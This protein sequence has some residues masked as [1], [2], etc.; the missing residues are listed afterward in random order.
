MTTAPT[1]TEREFTAQVI[2]LARLLGWRTAHFRPAWTGR[3]WRT[4]VQGDGAGFPD[5]VLV[6]GAPVIA[7]ELKAGKGKPS[8]EQLAWLRDLAA[9]GIITAVWR[10]E[11]FEEIAE[12][13]R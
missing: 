6:R 7:A 11:Q 8:D 12:V 4:P 10:P 3:G 2:E 5:L 9:A 13:L 1:I